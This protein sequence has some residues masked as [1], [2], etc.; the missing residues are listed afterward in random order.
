[1]SD[2]ARSGRGGKPAGLRP[3]SN[4]D[5]PRALRALLDRL[6]LGELCLHAASRGMVDLGTLAAVPDWRGLTC[7]YGQDRL[8]EEREVVR[9]ALELV[10]GDEVLREDLRLL[11]VGVLLRGLDV[12][13]LRVV[14]RHLERVRIAQGQPPGRRGAVA[15]WL[16]T[17]PHPPPGLRQALCRH[18]LAAK[19]ERRIG[20]LLADD[21]AWGVLLAA[22]L[23][24][25]TDDLGEF[26]EMH[27]ARVLRVLRGR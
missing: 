4:D 12:R 23:N 13:L 16:S 7:L 5:D 2:T 1:M 3:H 26:A 9:G 20:L 14:A 11:G 17:V 21:A 10:L 6:T 8:G 19:G 15:E 18:L 24:L 22:R 25:C 27:P